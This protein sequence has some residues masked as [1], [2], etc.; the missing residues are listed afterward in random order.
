MDSGIKGFRN[1]K[2]F[3]SVTIMSILNIVQFTI[4][5]EIVIF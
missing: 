4:F 1:Y 5:H 3:K 2:L